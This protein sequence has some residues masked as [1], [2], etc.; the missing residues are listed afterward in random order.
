MALLLTKREKRK[1]KNFLERSK[2]GALIA[3]MLN[4]YVI[5]GKNDYSQPLT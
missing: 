5:T 1:M 3:E 4:G 2:F